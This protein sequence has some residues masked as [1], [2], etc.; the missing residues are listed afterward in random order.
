MNRAQPPT[1]CPVIRTPVKHWIDQTSKSVLIHAQPQDVDNTSWLC[2]AKCSVFTQV[3]RL[4]QSWAKVIKIYI[5]CR[6]NWP[7]WIYQVHTFPLHAKDNL[8]D[9]LNPW[10][11]QTHTRTRAHTHTHT[12]TQ[13][14]NIA[15]C[16][17]RLVWKGEAEFTVPQ[18]KLTASAHCSS[19]QS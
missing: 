1:L 19:L 8:V 18:C 12:H 14:R 3:L 6:I 16:Q 4:D 2:M 5:Y 15:Y 9:R 7:G 17:S 10:A 13:Q 11:V